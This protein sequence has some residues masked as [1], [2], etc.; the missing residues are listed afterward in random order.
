LA[1]LLA[2]EDSALDTPFS[3]S[4][5]QPARMPVSSTTL[6]SSY[7]VSASET[8]NALKQANKLVADLGGLRSELKGAI[9]V[10][11]IFISNVNC[12]QSVV[13]FK[14]STNI[15]TRSY[16]SLIG[17]IKTEARHCIST[18]E[19]LNSCCS[20]VST[21]SSFSS[22]SSAAAGSHDDTTIDICSS[23]HCN[24]WSRV[25]VVCRVLDLVSATDG[26]SR[27]VHGTFVIAVYCV[28]FMF[29][30]L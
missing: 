8:E 1:E 3:L 27:R 10:G 9:K 26:A 7:Y 6:P 11:L 29:L 30:F 12:S 21:S 13:Q 17:C 28:H 5:Q 20:Q 25:R 23:I 2:H 19:R 22:S 14:W 4:P 15:Y 16:H 24:C 18:V